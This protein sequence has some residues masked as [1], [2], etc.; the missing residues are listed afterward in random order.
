[1]S[2]VKKKPVQK[3][4]KGRPI[5]RL[6]WWPFGMLWGFAWRLGMIS[7]LM[8]GVAVLYFTLGLPAFEKLVDGRTKGSVTLLDHRGDVFAWRGDQYGGLIHAG[9]VSPHLKDAVIATEDKRFYWHIGVDPR[10]ILSAIRINLRAGRGA[11]SG[12]G[13]STIT[14]QTAKL[15][16]LGMPF[17]ADIWSNEAAYERDC[18]RTTLWRKIK[19]AAYAFALELKYSKDE[20]LTIYMNRAFLGAGSRGFEAAAQR[21]F[22]ISAAQ[23]DIAQ[24]AMLAGLLKA[25]SLYA[26]TNNIKR[27]Q[28]RSQVVV[29]LMAAQGYI[30]TIEAELALQ[31]PAK[32]SQT[33]AQ[34]AGGYFADWVMSDGPDYFTRNT[35][36]D[37][38]IRTTFDKDMQKIAEQAVSSIFE[39][40]V[41][42][43]SKAQAA[44]VVMALDGAVLAMVGGRNT[45]VAGV[46]NRA[47]QAKRQTGSTFKP[48]VYAAALEQGYAPDA[49]VLDAPVGYQVPGSGVWSPQNYSR[50]YQGTITLAQ[51]LAQSLN[52]PAVKVSE[53]V[54]RDTVQRIASGFGIDSTAAQGPALA[55]GVTESTLLRMS[56]AYAAIANG[57]TAVTPYGLI[58]LRLQNS[59]APLIGQSGGKGARVVTQDVAEAL[60]YMMYE[61]IES[62]TGQR[63][64]LNGVQAAG[65]TGTTQSAK[66]AW[67]I[68]F[69]RDLVVGVWIGNDDNTPLRGVTGGTLPAEIWHRVAQKAYEGKAGKPLRMQSNLQTDATRRRIG[70]PNDTPAA[71]SITDFLRNLFGATPQ[72]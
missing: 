20:I 59:D 51:A 9:S 17:D 43:T 55:L 25:P 47:T 39:E 58:N 38:I 14:Q 4:P 8:L 10:G 67:F 1:M 36:E 2:A 68:G 48:F 12:N 57:G 24:A 56:A 28:D 42:P 41:T 21:Y 27:A 22:G 71:S 64:R 15:L 35:T 49:T 33:A 29:R 65:K 6:L 34:R 45:R 72:Q 60:T 37:V 53:A 3:R 32:L 23:T 54:G 30:S 40:R 18:R 50:E 46:F 11:L 44:V 5:A 70:P 61:A 63:A 66:D 16:C 62:G 13:G 69:T 19:E 52:I 26:P 7:A 31:N